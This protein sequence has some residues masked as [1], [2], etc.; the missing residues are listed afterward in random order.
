MAR[1]NL[2]QTNTATARANRPT[3]A[4][5]LKSAAHLIAAMYDPAT[6]LRISDLNLEILDSVQALR[7]EL[8]ALGLL[9]AYKGE[10]GEL[11][12]W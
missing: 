11:R 3:P 12:I 6:G 10:A 9:N 2:N 1:T 7:C 5:A 8:D 4:Q